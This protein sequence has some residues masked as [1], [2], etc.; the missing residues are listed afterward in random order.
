MK[1]YLPWPLPGCST[2][3]HDKRMFGFP[4]LSAVHL[5]RFRF[6]V[7]AAFSDAY[8]STCIRSHLLLQ[9][10]A[11]R[12]PGLLRLESDLWLLLEQAKISAL[13]C[14]LLLPFVTLF[15]CP[16]RG[17]KTCSAQWGRNKPK[18]CKTLLAGHQPLLTA[19][20]W[21]HDAVERQHL[22]RNLF[23]PSAVSWPMC[24]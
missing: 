8:T 24:F 14:V 1:D 4:K 9:Q 15:P 17:P 16:A 21:V 19:S 6:L 20:L 5:L 12:Q 7:V 3:L 23:V 13:H 11:T 2:D 22:C 10:P 18:A